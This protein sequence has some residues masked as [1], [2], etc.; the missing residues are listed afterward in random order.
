M[1]GT[2]SVDSVRGDGEANRLRDRSG[3]D[4]TLSDIADDDIALDEPRR[5]EADGAC[6][7]R[8]KPARPIEAAMAS[9]LQVE[10]T[11]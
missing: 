3:G 7:L 5:P 6:A 2:L 4:D 10:A 9:L 8:R 1:R 11:R